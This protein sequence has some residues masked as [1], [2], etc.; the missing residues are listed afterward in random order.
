MNRYSVHWSELSCA[1]RI[2]DDLFRCWCRLGD[3]NG[4]DH[5]CFR[6]QQEAQAW[7]DGC[8]ESWGR[9][10]LSGDIHPGDRQLG[11]LD[12]LALTM[13]LNTSGSRLI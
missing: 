1:Y 5:L 9:V 6:T 8:H 10:P 11:L 7:L 3:A 2:W 12:I 4:F 13:T